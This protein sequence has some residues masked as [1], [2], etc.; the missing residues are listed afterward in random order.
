MNVA[1]LLQTLHPAI[2]IPASIVS[3]DVTLL[4]GL[5]AMQLGT[6]S[7]IEL[8]LYFSIGLF[9]G[10][11]FF[12]FLGSYVR[13][14]NNSKWSQK[15]AQKVD[16]FFAET[17]HAAP[18]GTGNSHSL[19]SSRVDILVIAS[20]FLPGARV[21][22]YL[23]CGMGRYSFWKFHVL[24]LVTFWI[25][26]LSTLAVFKIIPAPESGPFSLWINILI[27]VAS[28]AIVAVLFKVIAMITIRAKQKY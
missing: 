7:S 12:Y 13:K 28:M 16:S 22:T 14:Y 20:R 3:E 24:L 21:P 26:Y 27:G 10:N 5:A 4:A 2:L 23:A 15:L 19:V 9:V 6:L 8:V 11:S 25:F 17:K 18:N 1:E